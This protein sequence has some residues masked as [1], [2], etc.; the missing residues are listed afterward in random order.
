MSY[1]E[2]PRGCH[3]I[4]WV[5]THDMSPG[6]QLSSISWWL[7][8]DFM[9]EYNSTM[10]ELVL[11]LS[12]INWIS[13]RLTSD[14]RLMAIV[15]DCHALRRFEAWSNIGMQCTASR[16][17]DWSRG[18]RCGI[19]ETKSSRRPQSFWNLNYSLHDWQALFKLTNC[20]CSSLRILHTYELQ[21]RYIQ[22]LRDK[23]NDM[24]SSKLSL[25]IHVIYC[26][27]NIYWNMRCSGSVS[28]PI[29]LNQLYSRTSVRRGCMR[30]I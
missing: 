20:S 10:S 24:K 18:V 22:V 11:I 23:N 14:E 1:H 8:N 29:V 15:P 4:P 26:K 5:P 21:L 9:R 17:R 7:C 13:G 6:F 25:S 30:P 2:P 12:H 19:R 16:L 3:L 27:L 28:E